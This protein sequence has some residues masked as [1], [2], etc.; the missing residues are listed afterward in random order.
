MSVDLKTKLANIDTEYQTLCYRLMAYEQAYDDIAAE[1]PMS[2]IK[3]KMDEIQEEMWA[4]RA[5]KAALDHRMDQ[6][7]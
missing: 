3:Q 6:K 1:E 2:Y 7:V 5:V 4:N